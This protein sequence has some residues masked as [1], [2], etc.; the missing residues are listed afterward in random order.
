MK[1]QIHSYNLFG[2][3]ALNT[4]GSTYALCP[5]GM[6]LGVLSDRLRQAQPKN[7]D[8][9][10]NGLKDQKDRRKKLEND[11][12]NG[13]RPSQTQWPKALFRRLNGKKNKTHIGTQ[14]PVGPSGSDGHRKGQY[15][16]MDTDIH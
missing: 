16:P 4:N 10:N 2:L 9:C 8:S 13:Q 15:L 6:R 1:K 3:Y 12:L 5:T 11:N 14:A 7:V